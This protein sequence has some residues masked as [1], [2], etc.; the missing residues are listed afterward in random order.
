MGLERIRL[1]A[2]REPGERPRRK[3]YE[4]HIWCI[5]F[6][7]TKQQPLYKKIYQQLLLDIQAGKYPPGSQL[8]TEKELAEAFGVSRITSKR[9]LAELA[10]DG[11]IDRIRGRGSFVHEGAGRSGVVVRSAQ[12]R[13]IGY[14]AQDLGYAFGM[15]LL[16]AVE[17]ETERQGLSLL[18]RLTG[19][20]QEAETAA[21][22]EM[23]GH[24]IAGLIVFPVNGERYNPALLK[25]YLSGMPV[26]LVDRYFRGLDIASVGTD[27][28]AA[29]KE[30]VSHLI[31]S[32]HRAIALLS[33]PPEGTVTVEDRIKGYVSAFVERNLPIDH[34]LFLTDLTTSLPGQPQRIA[35]ERDQRKFAELLAAHPEVSACFAVEY[36]LALV[37]Q[38]VAEAAGRRVPDDFSIVCFDAPPHDESFF[39]HVRQDERGMGQQAVKLLAELIT[40]GAGQD[41]AQPVGGRRVVPSRL[42]LGASTAP[43]SREQAVSH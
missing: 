35:Y 17:R 22:E 9:A 21:V 5:D 11:W 38:S 6:H 42:V 41:R 36:N 31:D 16:A 8:P 24:E 4:R 12:R 28:E 1:R 30:A 29:A 13:R 43:R 19:G 20:S 32:G 40:N 10:E 25:L 26:V 18:L 23:L 27:N 2:R 34:A 3:R 37:A 15:E 7:V 39:T 33:P 14:I